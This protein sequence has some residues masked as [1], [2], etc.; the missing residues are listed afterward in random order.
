MKKICFVLLMLPFAV[1]AGPI[2]QCESD[3]G[4]LVYQDRPC[5]GETLKVINNNEEKH[6]AMFTQSMVQALA[7]LTKKKASEYNDS[8]KLKAIEVLAMTDAAKSYAFTQVYAV[9]AKHCGHEVESKLLN[10]K[11]QASDVIALGEYYYS[12]GIE[13]NIDGKDFS[14]SGPKLSAAL[15]EMTQQLDQE[16]Q[17]ANPN[18]LSKK[19]KEASQAL[20]SLALLYSNL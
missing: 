18:Q 3:D 4:S 1:V 5:E 10:Y 15:L 19:C 11:N 13:A 17:T 14:Q 8:K 7:K 9:S 16:H 20:G 6:Q 12:Q 2:Y